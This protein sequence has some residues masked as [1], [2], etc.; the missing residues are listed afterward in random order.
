MSSK[1]VYLRDYYLRNQETLKKK[2]LDWHR[3]NPE[4]STRRHA[5]Y[6][7]RNRESVLAK[8]KE[9]AAKHKDQRKITL[10]RWYLKTFF[11]WTVE[12]FDNLLREQGGGC[13]VC[14]TTTFYGRGWHIDHDH[15]CCP[16]KKSCGKC[17]RGILCQKCN[18][19]LGLVDDN[20]AV[21]IKAAV[22]LDHWDK[23]GGKAIAGSLRRRIA[24][25]QEF[26]Q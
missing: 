10:R 19:A 18:A 24:E 6:Y 8:T 7:Q 23:A 20:S 5:D 4:E 12:G 21:L 11:N 26:G 17:I 16:G 13:A 22:Y 15:R 9:Y 25:E 1:Q 3:N 2:S 14:G